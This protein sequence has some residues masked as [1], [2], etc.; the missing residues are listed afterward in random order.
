MKTKKLRH[1][2]RAKRVE[3]SHTRGVRFLH[4][5]HSVGM[6][7]SLLAV[8]LSSAIFH[9][10]TANA[11]GYG[12]SVYPPLLRVHIKPSKSITQAFKID[13]LTGDDKFFVARLV[14]FTEADP[15]GNPVINL[16]A[17]AP[18]LNY[19]SLSNTN[20][21]FETPFLIKGN[22]SEQL[23]LSLSVP[24]D[25]QLRDIYA[26][27]L[28]S[29]YSNNTGITYQGSQI[30]ATTGSNMLITISTSA[31][32]PTL[33]H[34]ENITPTAPWLIKFGDY[35]IADSITPISFTAQ[36]LNSGDFS[37]E[38]KGIFKVTTQ[39][40]QAVWLE[41]VLPVNVISKT[42][43]SL[44]RTDGENFT[45]TPNLG[46][47]GQYKAIISIKTDNANT[48]NSINIVFLPLKVGLGLLFAVVFIFAI[49]K[50]TKNK[51]EL[52]DTSS[53]K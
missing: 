39:K 47:I 14:P 35:Y 23:V 40:D 48:E 12:L 30:S 22:S 43:R 13:N 4:S 29:T 38:T 37:A 26:T 21:K 2:E 10:T 3:R 9:P 18:W 16:K 49:T 20:I 6:T 36:V 52:V 46:N 7:I 42:F 24:E 8:F 34:V 15:Q 25:A 27:L 41:G 33:L 11:A 19:F 44:Q 53:E 50:T 5:F 45:F 17:T 51:P 31:Y 28:I 32:P 1:L